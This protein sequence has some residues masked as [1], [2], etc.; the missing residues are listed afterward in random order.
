M[1]AS[2]F[3]DLVRRLQPFISYQCTH[4]MP[5]DLRQRLA[6][7]LRMLASGANQ[8]TVATSY[9]L[10]PCTVSSIVSEICKALWKALQPEFLPCCNV[11]QWE[12][13]ATDF[14]RLWNFPNCVG[15]TEGKHVNIMAPPFSW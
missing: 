5:I 3:N 6:V 10:A 4:C 9:K 15:S 8:Q 11:V 14:C 13:I 2:R 12:A 1:S 7:T